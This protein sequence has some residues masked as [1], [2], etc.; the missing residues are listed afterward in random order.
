MAESQIHGPVWK[1]K[2]VF[3]EQQIITEGSDAAKTL[4]KCITNH[5]SLLATS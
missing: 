4:K 5:A 2:K 1:H 3:Q